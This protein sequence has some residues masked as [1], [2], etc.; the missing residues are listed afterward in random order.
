MGMGNHASVNAAGLK[1]YTC[2]EFVIDAIRIFGMYKP[3]NCVLNAWR[4]LCRNPVMAFPKGIAKIWRWCSRKTKKQRYKY[5]ILPAC[6]VNKRH[7]ASLFWYKDKHGKKKRLIPITWDDR[8]RAVT[9]HIPGG[10]LVRFG[11]AVPLT[12]LY[13][14]HTFNSKRT[15]VSGCCKRPPRRS[16]SSIGSR[17]TSGSVTK[18]SSSRSTSS[19]RKRPRRHKQRKRSKT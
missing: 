11:V 12:G 10:N 16:S 6:R 14:V 4:T 19:Q 1:Y 3:P 17:K 18:R 5:N 7:F 9:D 13:D 15:D 2:Q 8:L